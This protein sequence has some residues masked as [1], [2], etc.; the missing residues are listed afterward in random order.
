MSLSLKDLIGLYGAR[1]YVQDKGSR[2][3]GDGHVYALPEG[4]DAAPGCKPQD[5]AEDN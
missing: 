3:R 1:H 2:Q 5:Q 4:I